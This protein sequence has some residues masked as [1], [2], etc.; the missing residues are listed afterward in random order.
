MEILVTHP[1]PLTTKRVTALV[2][3]RKQDGCE[4]KTSD[5]DWTFVVG[6]SFG[7]SKFLDSLQNRRI[8]L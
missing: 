6:F 1:S 5:R 2:T 4:E 3:R 7:H 8:P